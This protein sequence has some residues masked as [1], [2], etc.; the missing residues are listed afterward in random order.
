MPAVPSPE[1]PLAGSRTFRLAWRCRTMIDGASV[2]EVPFHR[3]SKTSGATD[4]VPVAL[5][6]IQI[7]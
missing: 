1:P 6:F 2:A 4:V 5:K 7:M 3:V